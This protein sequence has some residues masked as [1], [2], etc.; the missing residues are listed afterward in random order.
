VATCQAFVGKRKIGL[1]TTEFNLLAVL[2]EN[3]DD[4]VSREELLSLVWGESYK[5]TVR[6]VD[7]HIQRLRRK[8]GRASRRIRTVRGVGYELLAAS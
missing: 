4:T 5:G 6:T 8:L 7:T 1:T 2:L 3:Q